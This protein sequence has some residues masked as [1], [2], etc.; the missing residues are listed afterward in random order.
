VVDGD[1]GLGLVVAPYAMRTAMEKADKVGTGWVSVRNSNHFGIAG[2]PCDDGIE[3]RY[4]RHCH[5]K[6]QCTGGSN[7]QY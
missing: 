7:F 1:A 6:R 2:L 5:D 3:K 4:D